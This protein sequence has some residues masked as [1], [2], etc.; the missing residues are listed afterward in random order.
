MDEQARTPVRRERRWRMLAWLVGLPAGLLI[1]LLGVVVALACIAGLRVQGPGWQG[2]PTLAG[3]QWRQGDCVALQGRDL[4]LTGL[5]PLRLSLGVLQL[6]SC[7]HEPLTLPSSPP[8]TPPFDIT[9]ARVEKD[10]LPSFSLHLW[11]Q[12]QHWH[13]T[14][15]RATSILRA[16]YARASGQWQLAGTLAVADLVPSWRGSLAVTGEGSWLSDRLAGRARVNGTALGPA[17]QPQRADAVLAATLANQHWQ[18]DGDLSAPLALPAGWQL[19]ATPA[20]SVRGDL[21]GITQLA[22][23]LQAQGPQGQARLQLDGKDGGTDGA[24]HLTLSGRELSGNLPLRWHDRLLTLTP[25]TLHL[26]QALVLTL[27]TPLDVPLAAS[28][29]LPLR[30]QL[31]RQDLRLSLP[32]GE[33]SWADGRWS[34][35]GQLALNGRMQGLEISGGWQGAASAQGLSGQPATLRVTGPALALSAELPVTGVRAPDW[36][37]QASLTGHYQDWPVQA[38]L[39]AHS[40]QGIWQGDVQATS[41][42]PLYDKGGAL[43]LTMPWRLQASRMQAMPGTRLHLAEGLRGNWLIRPLMLTAISPLS[44]QSGGVAGQLALSGDGLVAARTR[45]PALSG[46]IHLKGRQAQA[47]LTLPAWQSHAVLDA[48][49]T[50]QG[51]AG[52][53]TLDTPLTEAMSQGL[54]FTLH[55]GQVHT[56]A[57]WRWQQGAPSLHGRVRGDGLALDWGG[58]RAS[59]GQGSVQVDVAGPSAIRLNSEGPLRLATVDVG[60][61]LTD[62]R[63]GLSGD[64]QTWQFTDISAQVLGGRV[65]APALRWPS[66]DDQVV[67]LAGIDLAQVVVLQKQGDSPVRLTGTVGGELPLQLAGRTVALHQGWLRNEGPLTLRLLPSAGIGAMA[68]SNRAVQLALDTLSNL[69]ISDFRAA[70]NMAADGWLDAAVTVKG[71]S[72]QPNRQP[73]VLNYTHRENVLELLRSLRIGDEISQRVMDRRPGNP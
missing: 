37:L 73:V 24:G 13:L 63:L 20:L 51:V 43:T 35:T 55:R 26:P 50:D 53:L 67:T 33:L 40:R 70:L 29:R 49:L 25:T 32:A 68:Q 4:A 48:A 72:I 30:L 52:H 71:D 39:R 41:Q 28:G 42:V 59:G 38:T 34:W 1:C 12:A 45:L 62:V 31:Q 14:A 47:D 44:L 36:P 18:L 58:I 5:H 69:R 57:D 17:D 7:D 46:R 65:S 11:Q 19:R 3:W 8:W 2:G 66:A 9:I 64:L 60:T 15:A 27:P 54:G 6:H 22:V 61:P 10:A 23:D 16:D 21:Q 56:E